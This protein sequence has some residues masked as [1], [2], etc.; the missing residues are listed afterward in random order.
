MKI[1]QVKATLFH[2]ERRTDGRTNKHKKLIVV[3][4]NFAVEPKN[5]HEFQVNLKKA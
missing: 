1:C 4:R 5:I 3:F 2:V